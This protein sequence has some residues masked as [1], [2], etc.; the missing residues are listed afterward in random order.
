VG[1]LA[2]FDGRPCRVS[3]A[4]C[5]T[6]ANAESVA[7]GTD[8]A[9]GTCQ[10]VTAQFLPFRQVGTWFQW[11]QAEADVA[12]SATQELAL[13]L[14][15]DDC[16]ER[17]G[18]GFGLAIARTEPLAVDDQVQWLTETYYRV[19]VNG[20][21]QLTLDAQLLAPSASEL[22]DDPVLVGGVRAVWRF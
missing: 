3:W 5:G 10:A 13:G 15:I 8:G 6:D 16:F 22:V 2:E 14:T 17:R 19:Q 11:S 18:D 21:L 1:L 4:W 12:S 7:M 9:W 20:S